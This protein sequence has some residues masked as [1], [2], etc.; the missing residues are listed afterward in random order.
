MNKLSFQHLLE[1]SQIKDSDL[2]Q[3]ISLAEKYRKQG[4]QKTFS[5]GECRGKILAP[6]FFEPSTRTRLSFES[7]MTRL[8]GQVITL[9]NGDSASTKKG[10]TLSD[11]GRMVS[12][13][14]DIIV[15]RHPQN[16]SVAE[17]AKYATIP[18]INAGDG[19]NQHPT[20]ALTDI[21]TIFCEKKRLNN[22]KIGIVGDMKYGRTVHSLLTLLSRNLNNEFT[23][24]SHPSLALEEEKIKAFEANGCKIKSSDNLEESV[25][26]LDIIY[27]TRVQQER[28]LDLVEYEKV[29]NIFCINKKIL[30]HAK[31]DVIIMHPLPRTYEI[32][33]EIDELPQAKYFVQANY[34]VYIRMAL[35][36]LI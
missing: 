14:A 21:Y 24:I 32:D 6:L 34:A 28:F 3:L 30:S 10:E 9:E 20:Q 8:G 12:N 11:T 16:G 2:Q 26:D 31:D 25:K 33:P 18:V 19:T 1:A 7:A 17:L 15:M 5:D 35:L 22:L 23:L 29:K 13:Y 36:A 4:H 27:T